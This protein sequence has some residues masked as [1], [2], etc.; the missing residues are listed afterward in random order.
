MIAYPGSANI[1]NL[2]G[3]TFGELMNTP[4]VYS[5]NSLEKFQDSLI[6]VLVFGWVW[7]ESVDE[8]CKL[9][10]P[11]NIRCRA[12][13]H[14]IARLNS[15]TLLD[16][17]YTNELNS[18]MLISFSCF[19]QNKYLLIPEEIENIPGITKFASNV[20]ITTTNTKRTGG[21]S[22]KPATR[23]INKFEYLIWPV[24]LFMSIY[25]FCAIGWVLLRLY[26]P[27]RTQDKKRSWINPLIFLV[28]GMATGGI[29]LLI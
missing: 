22:V 28:S 1:Y 8:N 20:N 3:E 19:V 4:V 13:T 26:I 25:L 18:W 7:K 17:F 29:L 2:Q 9:I 27:H 15:G 24:R 10:I 12:N 5:L 14:I 11:E 23:P 21:V 16:T 6:N